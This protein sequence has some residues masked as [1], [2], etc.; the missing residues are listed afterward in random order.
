VATIKFNGFKT[1]VFTTDFSDASNEAF[2]YALNMAK[3]YNARLIILNIV[4][5]S[6]EAAGFYL[7]H[8][9][10]ENLD[11]DMLSAA[12]KLM[13]KKYK[14]RLGKFK[15][16]DYVVHKGSADKEIVKYSNKVMAD[17][18]IMGT[19]G[20]SGLDHLVFGSTTERVLKRA[21]CPVLAIHPK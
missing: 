16:F 1:I 4:D 2:T 20:H 12:L 9:S 8:L 13:E 6:R 19:Y 11:K 7:P 18:V 15:K 3:K 14:K 10:F 5:T 17:L 21:K